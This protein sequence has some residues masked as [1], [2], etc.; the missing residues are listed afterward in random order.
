M[1]RKKIRPRVNEV[2]HEYLKQY[3]RNK[4]DEVIL[5]ISDLHAPY[6]HPEAVNFLEAIK[7]KYRPTKILGI[8]DEVDFHALSFHDT[9][10]ELDNAYAELIKAR[11]VI[12]KIYKLFPKMDLVH[13]NHG[14]MLY[15]R[16]KVH[17]IPRH[18]LKSYNEVLEVGK[19]WK[20]H[21]DYK[22]QMCNGQWLF[23]TH[24][25][26]K[27]GL[28]LAKEMGMCVVQGHYHTTFEINYTSSPL[29]LNWN[30]ACGCL[31]DDKSMA[32]A[33]NKV[34]SQRVILGCGIII[35]GQPKLIPMILKKGGM[36]DKIV[37]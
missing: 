9:D 6:N 2:E 5:V 28:A 1:R 20:W 27:N 23:M 34:N 24:G 19:G 29:S 7:Y 12:K 35:N 25:L 17:G 21:I 10:P 32:F 8:G 36:W 14:S 4:G 26:K 11:K 30:L 18:M 3:R 31:I 37:H 16:G 33:Y 22:Y 15:R 13:S